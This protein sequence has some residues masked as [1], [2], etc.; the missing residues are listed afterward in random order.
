MGAWGSTPIPDPTVLSTQAIAKAVE[1]LTMYIDGQLSI[2]DERMRG[3]DTATTLRLKELDTMP[4]WVDEKVAHLQA[5]MD[6]QFTAVQQ[7]FNLNKLALDAALQASKEAVAAALAAQV[8][9]AAKQDE[10]NQKAI[11]KSELATAK[12]IS[13]NQELATARLDA[14]VKGL[15]EVKSRTTI[16]ESMKNGAQQDRSGLYGGIAAIAA[17]GSIIVVIIAIAAVLIE[18]A[19]A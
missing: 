17:I 1:S 5:L 18:S 8:S 10:A 2:R 19:P 16:I 9:A 7:Q 14:L 6:G 11:D 15:D 13:V 4:G 3:I 12:T